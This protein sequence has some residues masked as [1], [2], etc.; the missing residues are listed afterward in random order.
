MTKEQESKLLRKEVVEVFIKRGIEILKLKGES[1]LGTS[2]VN[3]GIE[4]GRQ[5]ER[6]KIEEFIRLLKEDIRTNANWVMCWE[7]CIDKL[8]RD[9]LK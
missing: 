8:I 2:L 4:I 3:W 5:E 7:E 1:G 6:E 9:K